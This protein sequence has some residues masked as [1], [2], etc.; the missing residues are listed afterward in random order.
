MKSI[1]SSAAFLTCGMKFVRILGCKQQILLK[2]G[3]EATG[4]FIR[5]HDLA[6]SIAGLAS[7]G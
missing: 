1:V 3:S 6:F 2:L 7:F 4:P 5:L